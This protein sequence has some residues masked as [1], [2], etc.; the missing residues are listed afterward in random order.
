MRR[1]E[2]SLVLGGLDNLFSALAR[3]QWLQQIDDGYPSPRLAEALKRRRVAS[4]EFGM[5]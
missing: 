4:V 2:S 3:T 5:T 1:V